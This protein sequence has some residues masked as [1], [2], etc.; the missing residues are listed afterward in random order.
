MKKKLFVSIV[1]EWGSD[2]VNLIILIDIWLL[3]GVRE[4]NAK[5]QRFKWFEGEFGKQENHHFFSE[6]I[7][8]GKK[9]LTENEKY[10]LLCKVWKIRENYSCRILS[11]T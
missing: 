3:Y 1:M 7:T 6:E 11:V 9:P 8:K 4:S 5:N 10:W 2:M